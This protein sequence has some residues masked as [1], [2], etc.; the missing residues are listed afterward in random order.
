M[1]SIVNKC[2]TLTGV[3]AEAQKAQVKIFPKVDMSW[4]GGGV[5][6]QALYTRPM[7]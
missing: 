7:A 2:E 1:E 4:C 3:E 6:V 5:C